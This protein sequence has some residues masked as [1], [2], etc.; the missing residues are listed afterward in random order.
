MKKRSK[1]IHTKWFSVLLTNYL[2]LGWS[3]KKTPPSL[4]RRLWFHVNLGS[5]QIQF[6]KKGDYYTPD[7]SS[8]P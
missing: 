4:N 5:C 2:N 6:K 3:I 8:Q 1:E 7:H